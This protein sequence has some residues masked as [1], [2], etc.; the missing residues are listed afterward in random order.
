MYIR[1]NTFRHPDCSTAD[2]VDLYHKFEIGTKCTQPTSFDTQKK[3]VCVKVILNR[4]TT[5]YSIN[6]LFKEIKIS[7][8][9]LAIR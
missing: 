1:R 9:R 5:K 6:I 4:M 8:M 3:F 2:D 7:I